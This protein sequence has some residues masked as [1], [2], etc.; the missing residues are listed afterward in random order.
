VEIVFRFVISFE[1]GPP[2]IHCLFNLFV[3]KNLRNFLNDLENTQKFPTTTPRAF[4]LKKI[5][6]MKDF[7]NFFLIHGFY[8]TDDVIMV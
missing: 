5:S 7:F 6:V 1:L 3:C 4:P 8:D 2:E